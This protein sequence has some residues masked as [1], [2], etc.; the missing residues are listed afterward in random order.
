MKRH[1]VGHA[2]DLDLDSRL[3]VPAH[4]PRC[5]G[6]AAAARRPGIGQAI[7]DLL[8]GEGTHS[9]SSIARTLGISHPHVKVAGPNERTRRATRSTAGRNDAA[10]LPPMLSGFHPAKY[11]AS[12]G[13]RIVRVI[14]S[15]SSTTALGSRS[16]PST[17]ATAGPAGRPHSKLL[18]ACC[19]ASSRWSE[20]PVARP[21]APEVSGVGAADRN[22]P[23]ADVRRDRLASRGGR[24]VA[25]SSS[26][27]ACSSSHRSS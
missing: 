25:R 17:S 5:R 7:G 15:G 26:R 3:R 8:D 12:A 6:H 11:P 10:W 16:A 20:R 21:D 13:R 2:D 14:T 19:G 23:R 18:T 22:H 9:L 24:P 1:V 4:S 27:W